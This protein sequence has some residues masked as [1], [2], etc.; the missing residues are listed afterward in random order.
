MTDVR[1]QRQDRPAEEAVEIL[2]RPDRRRFELTVGGHLAGFVRYALA[3]DV[4]T[5]IHT[6]IEPA[7]DG[8]G[9]GSRLARWVLDDARRRALRVRPQ[10][11][12]IAA[13]IRSHPEY[14]D[15]VV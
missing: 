8:R 1:D 11:P 6:E 10:C 3:E 7:F 14:H 13:Y 2:E 5:F 12:F 15:L 9:L 4:I